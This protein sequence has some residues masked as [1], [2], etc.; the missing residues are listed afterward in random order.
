M[1]VNEGFVRYVFKEIL[2]LDVALP[3][4]RMKY[5][6]AMAKY[7]SD[8]PDT[9]FGLEIEDLSDLLTG[10]A[11]K[12]FSGAL[13]GGKGSVRGV[14]AKGAAAKFT[15]KEIDKL[16]EL[17]KTY[18]AKGLA[19][20]RLS[21]EGESSSYEKFLTEE[22]KAAIRARL[23]A[24]PGDV[25]F[26]V[27]DARNDIVCTSLGQLRLALGN[28]LGLI[29]KGTFDLLWITD[30]PQF[31]W[32]E[33]ENRWMAMHHP[34]TCP[35]PGDEDR[36]ISDPGDCYARA[37]DMVIN[38]CEVGGGSIRISDPVVQAKMFAGLGFTEEEA[39]KRF[40]FLL[41]SF[42]YGVPPHGGMAFGLD[43]L[44]M[45]MLGKESIRDVIAFPKVQTATELMT[46]CPGEVEQKS[47]DELHIAV[48]LG[49]KEEK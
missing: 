29:P 7:G 44:V 30:F 2:D 39:R 35:R 3:L 4:R 42:Q 25:L 32:S 1:A 26:L 43:R 41:D 46:Q 33:E 5:N 13:E 28:E 15:R 34:F 11:F 31:E 48:V 23:G 49:D 45:L 22:E 38:G 40:G 21:P 6:D 27:A 8:K 16:T 37:Y 17:V 19:W 20:T 36:L 12:V 18:R 10:C 47:L 24:E 9:R 14:N